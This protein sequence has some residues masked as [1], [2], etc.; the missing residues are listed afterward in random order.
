MSKGGPLVIIEDDKDE[1]SFYETALSQLKI[2]NEIRFFNN[3]KDALEYLMTTKDTPFLIICD[4]DM[5]IMNGLELR[6]RVFAN[7]Y[8]KK[9]ATPF[10]YRTGSASDNHIIKA[11]DLSVQGFFTKTNDLDNLQHQ[12]GV[13]IQYWKECLEPND[14]I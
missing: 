8:L 9:K 7:P 13:I 6:E 1:R 4:M 5:P 12:L 14:H 11:Y 10:V 3:G 2:K